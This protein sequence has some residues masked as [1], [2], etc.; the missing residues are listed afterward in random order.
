[1]PARMHGRQCVQSL[2]LAAQ[3]GPLGQRDREGGGAHNRISPHRQVRLCAQESL[4]VQ[5]T[6]SQGIRHSESRR[7]PIPPAF[8]LVCT[9]VT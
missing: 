3:G 6:P 4:Q 9:L 2:L 8:S 1:M 7:L 5:E